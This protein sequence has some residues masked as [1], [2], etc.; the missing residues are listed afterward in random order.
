VLFRSQKMKAVFLVLSLSLVALAAGEDACKNDFQTFLRCVK[1]KYEA[2]TQAEKDAVKKDLQDKSDKCFSDAGCDAPDW[3]KDGTSDA[4]KQMGNMPESVKQCLKKKM[5]AK[6]GDKLNDCLKKKGV[7]NV[8]ITE[9]AEAAQGAGIGVEG[10]G[11]AGKDGMHTAISAKFNVVKSVDK[12]AQ[13]KGGTDS[14]K[15]LE[16][17]LQKIKTDAKPKVCAFVKS[18]EDA[19][20][21]PCKKR[22]KELHKAICQCKKEKEAEIAGKL[23]TLAQGKDKVGID[24]LVKTVAGDQDMNAIMDDVE[25]CY[26]DN[27]EKEPAL[28]KLAKA[29]LAKGGSSSN[30]KMKAAMSVN[31]SSCIIM[32]DMLQLDADDKSECEPCA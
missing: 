18:C 12:C 13:K 11:G 30:P 4:M 20:T 17:C 29:F 14:V 15:P 7:A 9:I 22:G 1:D 31:G 5:I 26:K 3:S 2:K 16:Q 21:A 32:A 27:N 23:R 8:N 28:L 19:V 24:E 6:L 25:Q 10:H